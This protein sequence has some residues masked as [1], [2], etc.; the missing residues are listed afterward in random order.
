MAKYLVEQAP[1]RA[2]LLRLDDIP[3]SSLLVALVVA[4][5]ASAFFSIAETAMMAVNRYR[6]RHRAAK[7]AR[8]AKLVLSLLA[9]TGGLNLPNEVYSALPYLVTF[10]V[11][12]LTSRLRRAPRAL[13]QPLPR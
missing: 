3:L 7:G 4:L 6:L 5:A 13:G 11:L 9:Q 2:P 8:G 12:L 1:A 10:V